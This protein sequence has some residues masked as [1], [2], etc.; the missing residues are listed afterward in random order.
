MKP[1]V[2]SGIGGDIRILLPV[3]RPR[4]SDG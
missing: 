1:Q 3:R 4:A 2:M